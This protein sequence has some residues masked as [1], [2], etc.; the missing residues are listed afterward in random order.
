[1]SFCSY[2][3]ST[4]PISHVSQSGVSNIE[5][6]TEH[7]SPQKQEVAPH[8]GPR[9]PL[10]RKCDRSGR[11]GRSVTG[12]I[13]SSSVD[14]GVTAGPDGVAGAGV[15]QAGGGAIVGDVTGTCDG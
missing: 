8:T 13:G 12:K 15:E 11:L 7:L 6:R 5:D 4:A 10:P 3:L 1:M 9:S 14:E 2:P